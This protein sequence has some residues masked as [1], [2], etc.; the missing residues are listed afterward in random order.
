[1]N[2]ITIKELTTR[3]EIKSFV[4]FNIDLYKDNEYFIPPLIADELNTLGRDTNPSFDYCDAVYYMAYRGGKPVGRIAGIVNNQVNN[5]T[6]EKIVRFGF[7]DFID[8]IEVSKALIEAV[9]KWGS[10]KGMTS[11]AGPLGFTDMD[12]EGML[13]EGF[14]QLGTMVALYNYP[15]YPEH[16][17]TLGFEKD[18]DWVEYKIH[19]PTAIPEKLQRV[20]SVVQAKTGLRALK[21][22][23]RKKLVKDYGHKLFELINTAYAELYGFSI[24]SER[25]IDYYLKNYISIVNLDYV[26]L[27][28][29][30]E[31]ELIGV[32]IMM[33]SLSEALRKS[34]GKMFPFGFIPLLKA[35]Y[36]TPKVL[37]MLLV[38]IRPDYQN[39]GA[40]ALFFNDIIP[41]AIRDGVRYAE[42]NPELELNE[43]VQAQ[44][45]YF[46]TEQHKRRRAFVKP[47]TVK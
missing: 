16:L 38:A 6:G 41:I 7:I 13:V 8:D 45:Q 1:M 33:P 43:K 26:T 34:G 32:G 36:S 18:V 46:E 39:K 29:N 5:S 44:W 21:Y 22:T 23:S 17:T 2:P 19:V 24:L 11:I 12:P 30:E 4:Q 42:S 9:E 3:A 10:S 15:Y 31:K 14:D 20:A 40:N 25:Q 28:V 27:I 47:I 37:D 35:L